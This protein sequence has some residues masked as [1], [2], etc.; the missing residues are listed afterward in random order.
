MSPEVKYCFEDEDVTHVAE[1]M[2][3]LQVRRLPVMNRDKRLVGIVSLGSLAKTAKAHRRPKR[4]SRDWKNLQR[5][6]Q[7]EIS[8]ADAVKSTRV[9]KKALGA[10]QV[11]AFEDRLCRLEEQLGVG[12]PPKPGLKVTVISSERRIELLER[13]AP[14][15]ATAAERDAE[16]SELDKARRVAA[17]LALATKPAASG[18]W[19]GTQV[20][21]QYA[22]AGGTHSNPVE[23]DGHGDDPS[24]IEPVGV[25][26]PATLF[27]MN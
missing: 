20:R 3:E 24:L 26:E 16:R 2:A 25:H 18:F 22:R 6:P 13:L 17:A 12:S 14:Q 11:T 27:R 19:Q 15:D 1:N 7:G 23:I 10:I 5:S 8:A 9:L 4:A 21:D